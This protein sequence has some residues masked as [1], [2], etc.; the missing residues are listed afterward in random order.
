M[1]SSLEKQGRIGVVAVGE[2]ET[3]AGGTVV[4]QHRPAAKPGYLGSSL[5]STSQASD[6]AEE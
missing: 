2:L 3:Q 1:L 5:M 4:H 6:R